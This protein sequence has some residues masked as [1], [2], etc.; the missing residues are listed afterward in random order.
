[1]NKAILMGRLTR[2]PEVRWS[3]AS[4]P[5][6]VCRYTLAVDRQFKREGSQSTDFINCV[7]F[8]KGG[9]FAE[10]WFKKGMMVAVE[11]S[12]RVDSWDDK[13]TGQ[14]RYSTEVVVDRQY[15]AE[16]KQS[17]ESRQGKSDDSAWNN[18]SYGS[19]QNSTKS[20]SKNNSYMEENN[21]F[22]HMGEPM[23]DDD[24]DLPF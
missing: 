14:K 16:S 11:G 13:E 19:F 5:M 21:S 12:I 6:A 24:E 3:Q 9:E 7:V 10:K 18:P 8:G 22:S 15:F 2:D 1:M 17:F 20:P 4:E 23:D